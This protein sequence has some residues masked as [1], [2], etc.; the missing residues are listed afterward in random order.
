MRKLFVLVFMLI[1]CGQEQPKNIQF[2]DFDE[3]AYLTIY[4]ADGQHHNDTWK[5]IKFKYKGKIQVYLMHNSYHAESIIKV[6]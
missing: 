4:N 2:I 3:D 6:E 5:I 1:G